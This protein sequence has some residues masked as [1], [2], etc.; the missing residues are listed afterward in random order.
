MLPILQGGSFLE[1]GASPRYHPCQWDYTLTCFHLAIQTQALLQEHTR[2]QYPDTS[3]AQSER[4]PI[5]VLSK[6]VG[7]SGTESVK[8]GIISEGNLVKEWVHQLSHSTSGFTE[9]IEYVVWPLHGDCF[10]NL[11]TAQC[12]HKTGSVDALC[13]RII[14][15]DWQVYWDLL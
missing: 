5:P 1:L 7:F 14:C 12:P 15:L 9:E 6:E 10:T 13:I 11:H 4:C 8:E 2:H 3:P